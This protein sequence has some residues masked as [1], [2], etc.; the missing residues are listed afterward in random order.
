MSWALGTGVVKIG[1]LL[2][3]WRIFA[4]HKFRQ[5]IAMVGTAVAITHTSLFFGFVFHCTPIHTFWDHSKRGFCIGQDNFYI[6]GGALNIVGDIIVLTLP[7]RPIW[8]L[9]ATRGQKIAVSF[10]FLLGGL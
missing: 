3:Y 7:L 10:L 8:A 9:H 5:V 1:I 4:I 2:F 6:S